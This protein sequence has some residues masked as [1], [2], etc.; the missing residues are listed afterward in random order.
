MKKLFC[1]LLALCVMTGI[2]F[3][4]E[5]TPVLTVNGQGMNDIIISMELERSM[6]LA[7]IR[8]ASYGYDIDMTDPLTVADEMDKML[9]DLELRTVVEQRAE[10]VGLDGFTQEE[11]AQALEAAEAEWQ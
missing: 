5:D 6:A 3:A 1:L 4:S 10:A 9:F 11:D 2:A 7:A 8:C